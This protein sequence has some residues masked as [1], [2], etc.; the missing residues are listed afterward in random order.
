MKMPNLLWLVR[1]VC[2]R[3]AL[4]AQMR[5]ALVDDDLCRKQVQE[6]RVALRAAYDPLNEA[7]NFAR[8]A[9]RR[10]LQVRLREYM[11]SHA[12]LI[13]N[14]RGMEFWE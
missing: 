2:R 7:M 3:D 1:Y 13:V 5:L 11:D 10:D 6:L 14:T 12:H 4:L 8:A 9:G